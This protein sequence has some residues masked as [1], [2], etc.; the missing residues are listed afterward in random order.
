MNINQ[1]E[2][3]ILKTLFEGVIQA[4]RLLEFE[5]QRINQSPDFFQKE[6]TGVLKQLHENCTGEII[7]YSDFIFQLL[8]CHERGDSME[9]EQTIKNFMELANNS[10]EDAA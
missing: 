2:I 9:F 5:F 3:D 8:D 1:S 7:L 6:I 10:K 4:A